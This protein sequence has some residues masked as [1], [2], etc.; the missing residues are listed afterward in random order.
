VSASLSSSRSEKIEPTFLQVV[1][2][3]D[4]KALDRIRARGDLTAEDVNAANQSGNTSLMFAALRSKETEALHL[5][6]LIIEC[7]AN[8]NLR[9]NEGSTALMFASSKS[10]REVVTALLAAGALCNI[11]NEVSTTLSAHSSAVFQISDL[12]NRCC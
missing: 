5:V 9:N 6:K 12:K 2:A 4:L 10:H 1:T 7:G 8:V 11:E 3:N